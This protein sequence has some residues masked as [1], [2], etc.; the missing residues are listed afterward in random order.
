MLIVVPGVG[1]NFLCRCLFLLCGLCGGY[2]RL[3]W[4]KLVVAFMPWPLLPLLGMLARIYIKENRTHLSTL[5]GPRPRLEVEPHIRSSI[6][7]E[8]EQFLLRHFQDV[9][10]DILVALETHRT[11]CLPRSWVDLLIKIE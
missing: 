11:L 6:F 7:V 4:V 8:P 10:S 9:H 1:M 5:P 3:I 2:G